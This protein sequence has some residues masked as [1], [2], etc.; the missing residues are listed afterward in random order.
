M[1][2]TIIFVAVAA[3]SIVGCKKAELASPD[4]NLE[5][6]VFTASITDLPKTAVV[7]STGKVSWESDD[8][9]TITDAGGTSVVYQVSECSG[10]EATFVKKDGQTDVLGSA[11]Y[12][13]VYGSSP[14]AS[15]TWSE[16]VNDL[17][18]T[19]ESMTTALTFTVNCGILQLKLEKEGAK[20]S[21]IEVV[22]DD[23]GK[24][25]LACEQAQSIDNE[26]S[27]CVILPAGTYTG[28]D[29]THAEGFVC[30]NTVKAGSELVI[31]AGDILPVSYNAM[32]SIIGVPAENGG[33]EAALAVASSG[34]ELRLQ[35]GTFVPADQLEIKEGVNI[36]GGW[37]ATF[38]TQSGK[39]TVSGNKNHRVFVQNDNFTTE[40]T[41]S[42]LIIKDGKTDDNSAST[43]LYGGGGIFMRKGLV[44]ENCEIT[45]CH[46]P[47]EK[48]WAGGILMQ[49]GTLRNSSIH[50]NSCG[51]VGGALVT[52]ANT[53][54]PNLN[55]CVIEDCDIY[56]N[57]S[58]SEYNV[59]LYNAVMRRCRIHNNTVTKSRN[60][61]L[62]QNG[63][64]YDCLFYDN[65]G[66]AKGDGI[67]LQCNHASNKVVNCTFIGASVAPS[68]SNDCAAI[69]M[70][71]TATF[72]NNVIYTTNLKYDINVNNKQNTVSYCFYTKGKNDGYATNCN[73]EFDPNSIFVNLSGNDF[74]PCADSALIDAGINGKSD[75]TLDLDKKA[76]VCG[77]SVDVGCY[78]YQK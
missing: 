47:N 6:L 3:L 50:G 38:T 54:A 12:A 68:V 25:T 36:S 59:Q 21:K 39:S 13:A 5:E 22:N 69:L 60:V 64:L 53:K 45:D 11:P 32:G 71:T 76:R 63:Y 27:F 65:I 28:I 70:S 20:I 61:R 31:A 33:L 19:A 18:M 44:V 72:V 78:E 42:N 62:Q 17:P 34:Q 67:D 2:K 41:I 75:S 15:Q 14:L 24:Y 49:G 29:F 56:E 30:K 23:G 16:T 4:N 57:S 26:K 74:H 77:T 66:Q 9:I 48:G 37:D 43:T 52:N 8:E 35:S 1:K 51:Y 73:K 46:A 58:A 7:P 10:A 55:D 40:T